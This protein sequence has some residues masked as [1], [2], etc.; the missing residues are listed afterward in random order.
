MSDR[1]TRGRTY[2]YIHDGGK[3]LYER[4]RSISALQYRYGTVGYLV[5]KAQ[6]ASFTTASPKSFVKPVNPGVL[7]LAEPVPSAVLIGTLTHQHTENM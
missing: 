7:V 3:W 4:M 6:P 5:L 2:A 1:S